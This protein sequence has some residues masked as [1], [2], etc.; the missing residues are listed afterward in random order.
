[1]WMSHHVFFKSQALMMHKQFETRTLRIPQ[2]PV[3]GSIHS[4]VTEIVTCFC[5]STKCKGIKEIKKLKRLCWKFWAVY[6]QYGDTRY[7]Y[8]N[9]IALTNT[10]K[11]VVVQWAVFIFVFLFM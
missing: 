5:F 8:N 10:I 7:N 6:I 4:S 9:Y 3:I 2:K 11:V 1:M